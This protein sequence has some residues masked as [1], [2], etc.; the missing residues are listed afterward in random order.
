M[1]GHLTLFRSDRVQDLLGTTGYQTAHES[2]GILF[3]NS[4]NVYADHF[5]DTVILGGL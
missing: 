3:M 5:T 4:L 1:P 2:Q